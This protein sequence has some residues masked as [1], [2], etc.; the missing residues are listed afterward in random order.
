MRVDG[1]IVAGAFGLMCFFLGSHTSSTSFQQIPDIV[2]SR[3]LVQDIPVV[4]MP[5]MGSAARSSQSKFSKEV[6]FDQINKGLIGPAVTEFC[7]DMQEPRDCD[8]WYT[9]ARIQ[10]SVQY[11]EDNGE[12]IIPY[13]EEKLAR[14][15]REAAVQCKVIDDTATLNGGGWCLHE[16]PEIDKY[17]T[18]GE[19]K[20]R[21]PHFHLLPPTCI[22]TELSALI[23]REN[24]TSINDFGA[25]VGQY[26][27]AILNEH[28]KLDYRGYDGA[29]NVV[30]YTKGFL[31]YADLTYPLGKPK[32][33]W[34]LSLEV[35][36]HVPST[37]EGMLIR[38]LHRHNRKGVILSWGIL[39]QDGHNHVNN[40][41]NEYIVNMMNK[42]GYDY[43]IP[44]SQKFRNND[45]NYR[46]FQH[47][48]MV[49]RRKNPL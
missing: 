30:E 24:I 14:R 2:E 34:V 17:I 43:D 21:I 32:A 25:G 16:I 29:G 13:A 10:E 1:R 41:A 28:P 19:T 44:L 31:E 6:E 23:T 5:L 11:M 22:V 37:H 33:D 46:W 9:V 8:P 7:G 48:V 15:A 36:E 27:A 26:K 47:S 39:G 4:T 35:G 18:H 42:L 3:A 49:F 38:N 12:V 40:H 20:I 45:G